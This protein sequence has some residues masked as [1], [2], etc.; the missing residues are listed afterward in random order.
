[1]AHVN[2]LPWRESLRQKKKQDYLVI[3]A[4]TAIICTTIFWLIG[5]A[6]DQQI[7]NQNARNQFLQTEIARLD[8]IIGEIQKVK[9]SKEEIEKRMSL[10][11]Q[12]QLSRNLTPIIMDELVRLIPNG[13]SFVKMQRSENNI[14]IDGVSDSNNRLSEF[15]RQLDNSKVFI[16]PE[17]SSIVADTSASDAVSTFRL[18]VRLNNN[19]HVEKEQAQ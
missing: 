6:I 4:S 7:G 3:L 11:E 15:M 19:A 12:L 8:A 1:M 18:T 17:L 13:V 2:L 9:D 10:I 14:E 16:N 5:Q